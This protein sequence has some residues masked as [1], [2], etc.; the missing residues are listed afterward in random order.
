MDSAV[1][2]L[3]PFL[4]KQKETGPVRRGEEDVFSGVSPEDY[5]VESAGVMDAGFAC[6]GLR[7]AGKSIFATLQA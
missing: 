1:E 6:H 5:V 7:I 2:S 3:D 4:E